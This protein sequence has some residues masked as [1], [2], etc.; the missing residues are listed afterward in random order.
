MGGFVV[1]VLRLAGMTSQLGRPVLARMADRKT[2][3]PVQACRVLRVGVGRATGE[4]L[5]ADL[6]S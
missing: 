2:A 3:G 1:L 5:G 4:F 6:G